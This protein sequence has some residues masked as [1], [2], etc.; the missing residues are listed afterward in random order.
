MKFTPYYLKLWY[1]FF[2]LLVG[3]LQAQTVKDEPLNILTYNQYDASLLELAK[4]HDIVFLDIDDVVLTPKQFTC[5][6]V[7]FGGYHRQNRHIP[8]EKLVEIFYY[9]IDYMQFAPVSKQLNEDFSILAQTKPV[10]GLTARRDHYRNKTIEQVHAVGLTFSDTTA[11]ADGIIFAGY[12]QLTMTPHN[13]GLVVRKMIEAEEFGNIENIVFFDDSY[14][15]LVEVGTEVVK[16]GLGF[17]GIHLTTMANKWNMRFG[18]LF[19]QAVGDFQFY[20]F[21]DTGVMLNDEQAFS[22]IINYGYR[23][24]TNSMQHQQR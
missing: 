22:H 14:R 17:T 6:S 20:M 12:N 23:N 5:G 16:M 2:I 9:C 7:W 19:M 4:K 1:F 24:D 15:N 18:P 11:V 3:Q 8:S 13:K 21:R 10:I